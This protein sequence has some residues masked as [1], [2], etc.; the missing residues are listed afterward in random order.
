MLTAS[1]DMPVGSTIGSVRVATER[2]VPFT[3]SG[4]SNVREAKLTDIFAP[5][6]AFSRV[7]ATNVT[8]ASLERVGFTSGGSDF[9]GGATSGAGRVSNFR[10]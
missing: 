10:Q 2:D 6:P 9:G 5:V 7:F 8:S 3:C 4:T 1:P